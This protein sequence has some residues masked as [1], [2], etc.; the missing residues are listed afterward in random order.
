MATETQ[1]SPKSRTVTVREWAAGAVGGFVGSI[2]F[3]V[4]MMSVMPAP[5]L[6]IVIPAMYGIEGPALVAGWAV[7]QFHGVVLGVSYVGL[8]QFGAIRD[9]AK[10]LSGSLGLGVAYGIL[11]TVV[12]AA[13][14]MPLW[15]QIV[16]FPAAP[17]FP[18]VGFPA[19]L[20]SALG[21]TLYAVP[22]AV[23]Y[24][25]SATRRTTE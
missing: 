13:L 9:T 22:V 15:L 6:E 25:L 5:M 18:N 16:G 20:V 4:M 14:V 21:H 11:T 17:P 7:H 8:V 12:L 1:T 2:V 3:G 19:T 24:A 10:S 23:G